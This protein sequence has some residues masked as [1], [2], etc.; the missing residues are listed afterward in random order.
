MPMDPT[1]A[2]RARFVALQHRNFTLLW[3]GLLVSNVGT[4]MQ[5]VA[6]AWLISE[7]TNKS[8]LWL[9]LL[10]L[11]FGLPMSVLPL[12][13]GAIIDRVHRIKLLY[14]TQTGSMVIAFVLAVLTWLHVVTVWHLLV[15]TFLGA[16]LL[17]FD[18]PARQ[19]L[20]PD[21][22]PSRD[23]LNALSLNSATYNGAALV[24]PA[25]AGAVL[26]PFGAVP[27][28]AF[29]GTSFLAVL[30]ALL[31]MRGVRTHSGGKRVSLRESVG[32]GFS[33]AWHNRLV[34][35]LLAV[36]GLTA[37]FGRSYQALLPDFA[38]IWRAGVQGYGL[39]LAAAG[40]GAIVGAFGLAYV[41]EVRRQ[42]TVMFVA[43]VVFTASIA[44]FALS[45]AFLPAVALMFVAGVSVTVFGTIIA[46]FIQVQTPNELRGRVMSFYAI[47]LIGLP[48]LGALGVG[49][50]A[51]ILGGYRAAPRAVL[52]GTIV[53]A[54]GLLLAVPPIVRAHIDARERAARLLI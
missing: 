54:I 40:A 25:I 1:G 50:V 37:I 4:W 27:I 22:V 49:G 10:G 36:S 16:T 9:G 41:R 31:A 53:L 51:E 15:A 20:V 43:G 6:V 8:P 3:S 45:P 46:T 29:N 47:T 48:S 12:F 18:N 34:F 5:N 28:F 17:A 39:L 7:L 44:A 14:V 21:L 11:S 32:A 38:N 33:F 42:T 30:F 52:L 26:G 2:P 13:S 19:A 24:G 23:L 35:V